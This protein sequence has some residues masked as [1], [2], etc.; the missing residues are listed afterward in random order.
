MVMALKSFTCQEDRMP[1]PTDHTP[2]ITTAQLPALVGDSWATDVV[3]QLPADLAAQAAHL[4][5][6]QRQRG[7]ACPTD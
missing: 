2:T 6:F 3:P 7:L 5:A 4:G 1:V